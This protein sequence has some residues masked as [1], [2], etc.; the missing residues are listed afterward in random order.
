MISERDVN[1]LLKAFDD[2]YCLIMSINIAQNEFHVI[3]SFDDFTK[4]CRTDITYDELFVSIHNRVHE[5][6]RNAFC[7]IF[8]RESLNEAFDNNEHSLS[9][10]YKML[11]CDGAYH[12]FKSRVKLVENN[13]EN[14]TLFLFTRLIDEQHNNNLKKEFYINAIERIGSSF[15]AIVDIDITNDIAKP[16]K[17]TNAPVKLFDESISYMDSFRKFAKEYIIADD[18]EKALNFFKPQ[19]LIDSL[20]DEKSIISIDVREWI[21]GEIKWARMQIQPIFIQDAQVKE[22]VLAIKD[23]DYEKRRDEEVRNEIKKRQDQLIF[24]GKRFYR[25]HI[26]I[27]LQ[28][29]TYRMLMFDDDNSYDDILEGKYSENIEKICRNIKEPY[30]ELFIREA[31]LE[32]LRERVAKKDTEHVEYEY[33]SEKDD[34]TVNKL[35]VSAFVNSSD[36]GDEV[37]ISIRDITEEEKQRKRLEEALLAAKEANKAKSRFLSNMSHDMRTPMNAIVGMTSIAKVHSD[38]KEKVSRCLEQIDTSSQYLLQLINNVLDMSV[39]ESGNIKLNETETKL[40]DIYYAVSCIILPMIEEAGITIRQRSYIVEHKNV[41]ADE[42]KIR[43][44]LI[45]IFSNAIKYTTSGGKIT[46][47][48]VET[49]RIGSDIAEYGIVVSDTGI[50]MS[51]DFVKK[52]G[53]PFERAGNSTLSKVHGTGLGMTITKNFIDLMDGDI[54]I[55]S[56]E[57]KGTTVSVV[58]R[59]K[60][61]PEVEQASETE[62]VLDYSGIRVLVVD[63]NKVN[64]DIMKDYLDDVN[65]QYDMVNDGVDCIECLKKVP[66]WYYDIIF[67]DIQ[68]PVMDGYEATL[69]L[70]DTP[71]TYLKSVPI[72]A[73][74]ANAFIADVKKSLDIGMDGH[75][76]KPIMLSRLYGIIEKYYK[77]K[78]NKDN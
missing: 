39:I 26:Y 60:Y 57:G 25:M 41:I 37:L 19:N 51:S 28:A 75:L 21:D 73:L 29:D 27:D 49:S 59:L 77:I 11:C 5:L 78:T 8:S 76:A 64:R 63:D 67:M 54:S 62:E 47:D 40:E 12:W 1:N 55:E 61:I 16:I 70:R 22:Y 58:L 45:N 7:K 35:V 36:T 24:I 38:D 13:S 23:I 44:I 2:V 34:G 65:V 66:D 6:S 32:R 30:H 4:L 31:S 69:K 17:L 43:Q 68:M 53:Q 48:I 71:R 42:L 20:T 72:I 46:V 52:V 3:S 50:G 10:E 18:Y 9:C 56:E 33:I 14:K 74:T 15:V